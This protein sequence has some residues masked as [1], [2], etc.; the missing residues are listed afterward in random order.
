MGT[1]Y[2]AEQVSNGARVAVKVL[3]AEHAQR[4]DAVTR[5][6]HEAEV[7]G[8]LR[9]ENICAVFDM[10]QLEDGSPYVVMERLH[11]ETMAK[12]LERSGPLK[13]VDLVDVLMQVLEGL[14]AAHAASVVHRDMKPENIFLARG[15]PRMLAKILDF[16][17]SKGMGPDE[18]AHNLTRT[19][20]VMG[21][22]YYMS[23]E[24]AMGERVLDGRVDIWGVGVSL[25]EGL[26]G[27][28]PF[29]AKNYNALLVQIL[30]GVPEPIDRFRPDIPPGLARVTL[31]A[32]EKRR[33][34]RYQSADEFR[35]ALAPYRRL[36]KRTDVRSLSG[37][38]RVTMFGAPEDSTTS[39]EEE[40]PTLEMEF[41]RRAE[42]EGES[43]DQEK[44][45]VDPPSFAD[46]EHIATERRKR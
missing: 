15:G 32:L 30:S 8:R 18:K 12:R 34:A 22:P 20:M 36:P 44:T 10:G 28:R 35:A 29:V 3:K 6:R 14:R 26:T 41:V 27:K 11:G 39:S 17:I 33:D 40:E 25:Y 38:P 37:L 4:P 43:T 1:V 16:G 19:G 21:T 7:V 42:W 46:S 45:E 24:Q 9:Q 2:E 5:L 13:Y 31:R 23:P